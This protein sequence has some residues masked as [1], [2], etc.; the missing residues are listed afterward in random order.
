[1]RAALAGI[2]EQQ[3]KFE[4][5]DVKPVAV[6]A[7]VEEVDTL[8]IAVR[9][10]YNA[11]LPDHANDFLSAAPSETKTGTMLEAIK[12]NTAIIEDRLSNLEEMI[13]YLVKDQFEGNDDYEE[14]N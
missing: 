4:K 10:V 1:M 14:G 13:K 11:V 9:G 6:N 2:E 12:R 3:I 8:W 5:L 7:L